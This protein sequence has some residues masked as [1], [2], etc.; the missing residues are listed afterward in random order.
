MLS[1]IHHYWTFWALFAGSILSCG[2]EGGLDNG[3]EPWAEA[4][5]RVHPLVY[6]T[7]PLSGDA[8]A[9]HAHLSETF[10]ADALTQAYV[11][12]VLMSASLAESETYLE[13][14]DVA[15]PE[16]IASPDSEGGAWVDATWTVA[17]EVHH[18]LHQH[19]RVNRYRGRFHLRET[20]AG[21]RIDEVIMGSVGGTILPAGEL[22]RLRRGDAPGLSPLDIL[23]GRGAGQ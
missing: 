2:A 15:Y 18:R 20:E 3:S 7:P 11:D 16:V 12:H 4:F 22:E 13:I 23:K 8:D 5:R 19:G 17:G 1:N 9:L 10:T 14:L 6:D 21:P